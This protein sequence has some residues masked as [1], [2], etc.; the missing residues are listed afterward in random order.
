ML[1]CKNKW[2]YNNIFLNLLTTL[3]VIKKDIFLSWKNSTIY[4][5]IYYTFQLIFMWGYTKEEKF[6]TWIKTILIKIN[7]LFSPKKSQLQK[8]KWRETGIL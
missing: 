7:D 4:S 6:K 1:G 2:D 8:L 5:I 3:N